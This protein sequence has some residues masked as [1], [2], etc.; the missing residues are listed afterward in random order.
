MGAYAYGDSMQHN[1]QNKHNALLRDLH[2]LYMCDEKEGADDNMSGI[3][4]I[5]E[6]IEEREEN[7]ALQV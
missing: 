6:M 7:S 4:L 5:A 3:T 2:P 1:V